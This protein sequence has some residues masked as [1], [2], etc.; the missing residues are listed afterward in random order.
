MLLGLSDVFGGIV[1]DNSAWS[2]AVKG[3]LW[4]TGCSKVLA[5]DTG[6]LGYSPAQF[7]QRIGRRGAITGAITEAITEAI[8][9]AITVAVTVAIARYFGR[10]LEKMTKL[11]S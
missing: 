6:I 11:G 9:V 3:G 8:T 2:I 7:F 10:H 4:K 5:H 1:R